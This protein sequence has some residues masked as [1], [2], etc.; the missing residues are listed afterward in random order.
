[1]RENEP[2]DALLLL[3]ED[4]PSVRE[5]TQLGLQ[6]AGFQVIT[7]RDGR[8]GLALFRS[9]RPDAV[10]L[11]IMLPGLDGLAV[12]KA[13]RA[14]SAVPVVMLTALASTVDVVVGLEAGADDYV[15]KP[16]KMP[17]L[18]ARVR[19]AL[20]RATQMAPSEVVN[21]GPLQIDLQAHTVRSPAGEISLTPTE[22]RLLGVLA[23]SPGRVFSREELITHALGQDFTGFDRTIDAHVKNL[24]QKIETDAHHPR[25]LLTVHGLGYRFQAENGS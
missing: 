9:R 21:L 20:R 12:C 19:A 11:D 13:I 22:F 6:H 14:E 24:R 10:V 15:T 4:D 18:V 3:V 25:Y 1:M 5:V 23:A 16:F 8:E 17:E 2:V 7:A